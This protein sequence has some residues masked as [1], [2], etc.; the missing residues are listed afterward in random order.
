MTNEIESQV[1]LPAIGLIVT[2]ILNLLLGAYFV[3]SI[4]FQAAVGQLNRPFASN[5]ERIGFYVGF[6]GL[7]LV[8]LIGMAIA[9]AI[10]YGGVQM[11]KGRKYGLARVAS[12][13][14]IIPATS[15]C[16]MVGIPIGIWSFIVL[17][18][19]EVKQYFERQ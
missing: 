1:K 13:L 2:G 4:V 14:A 6:Y 8:A 3:L 10:I 5:E 19:P 7:G 11:L 17:R 15:C 16:F 12:I 9:P 18:K